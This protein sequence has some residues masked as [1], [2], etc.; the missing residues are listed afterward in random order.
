MAA[1]SVHY[2]R[3]V[4]SPSDGW[5]QVLAAVIEASHVTPA[6]QLTAS[7]DRAVARIGLSAQVLLVDLA[8][9]LLH[10]VVAGAPLAPLP[11][12]STTAG[13][14]YQLTEIVATSELGSEEVVDAE[15]GPAAKAAAA[16]LLW[17][18][19]FDGT[20][21]IGVLRVGLGAGVADDVVLRRWLWSLAGLVGHVVV[22]KLGHSV[23]LQQLRAGELSTASELMWNLLP[24]RTFATERLV[25]S[26]LLEPTDQVAGDAYDYALDTLLDIAVFDG[27]GHDLM[28]GMSTTLAVTAIR[29][30]RRRGISDLVGQAARA[31]AVLATLEGPLRFVTAVLARLD[32]DSGA[33]SYL[34]AGHPPPLLLRDGSVVKQLAHPPRPPLGIAGPTGAWPTD[35]VGCEQLKPG[36]RVLLYSDGVT[37]ARDPRGEFFGEQRLID[38]A[39]RAELGALSAPETLR[40]LVAAVLAHQHGRLQDDATLLLLEWS[41]EGHLR[42]FPTIDG[43]GLTRSV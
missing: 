36:D 13:R 15:A 28:A 20:E 18:P 43:P 31:D 10:P 17:I 37:E 21:R 40:R 11:V 26:A 6:E 42:L 22:S 39:E 16:R 38:M 7:V 23:G 33:L 19:L 41:G 24:P 29:N 8:Q 9:R 14:C 32:T 12:E 30:A 35:L 5:A 34:L 25:V 27:V 3:S 1:V 2:G 4:Q